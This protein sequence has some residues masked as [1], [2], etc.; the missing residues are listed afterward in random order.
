[1][2]MQHIVMC[3]LLCIAQAEMARPGVAQHLKC[4]H[5][6]C[7]L[8]LACFVMQDLADA[9]GRD[10]AAASLQHM[11]SA[12]TR[13]LI[14]PCSAFAVLHALTNRHCTRQVRLEESCMYMCRLEI[15]LEQSPIAFSAAAHHC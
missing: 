3:M 6:Q 11:L 15:R 12:A 13:C 5:G 9:A 2:T 8:M 4:L 1:M 10:A 14:S 7:L